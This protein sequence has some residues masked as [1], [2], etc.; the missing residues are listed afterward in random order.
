MTRLS[1]L[2]LTPMSVLVGHLADATKRIRVGAGGV[3]L[4]NHAPLVVAEQFSLLAALHPARIDLGLGRGP[5]LDP[6][7]AAALRRAQIPANDGFRDRLTDVITLLADG[8]SSRELRLAPGG[9]QVPSLWLL[10]SS[11]SSARLAGELG[12]CFSFSHHLRWRAHARRITGIPRRFSAGA[13]R[14]SVCRDLGRGVLRRRRTR[15]PADVPP[16]A[17]VLL[18]ALHQPPR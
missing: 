16:P 4:P 9:D 12:L 14:P 1:V 8:Q 18:A 13:R 17:T 3:M 2:D 11:V 7:T 15:R 5:V 6:A 10:G